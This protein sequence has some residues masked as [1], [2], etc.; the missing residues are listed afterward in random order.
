MIMTNNNSIITRGSS[1]NTTVTNMTL[2]NNEKLLLFLVTN[3]MTESDP[4]TPS[5]PLMKH[6]SPSLSLRHFPKPIHLQLSNPFPKHKNQLQKKK[7]FFFF[8]FFI[9]FLNQIKTQRKDEDGFRES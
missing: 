2:N 3:G 7:S 6:L 9:Y 5:P 4:L 1:K 8:I